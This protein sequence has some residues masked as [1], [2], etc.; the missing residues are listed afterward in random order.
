MTIRTFSY[1]LDANEQVLVNRVGRMIRCTGG[2]TAFT[3]QPQTRSGNYSFDQFDLLD[4]LG[5]IVQNPFDQLIITNGASAQT[6]EFYVSNE[7]VFD[8]RTNLNITGTVTTESVDIDGALNYAAVTVST[9]AT[10]IRAQNTGRHRI[11]IY[12]NG[13]KPVYLGDDTSVTTANGFPVPVGQAF[14][15]EHYGAVYGIA[16][17][18]C[19][20]RYW[21]E[22]K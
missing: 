3:V 20:V 2:D 9:T 1:T 16:S 14:L 12:N 5:V 17:V 13:T 8:S 6:I 11:V 22:V 15:M 19:D 21:E 18:D 7:E 4:G 10:A